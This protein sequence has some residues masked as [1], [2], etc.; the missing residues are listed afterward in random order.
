[1]FRRASATEDSAELVVVLGAKAD[2]LQAEATRPT[3]FV[4]TAPATRADAKSPAPT[5]GG[6]RAKT[7]V[8]LETAASIVRA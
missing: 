1:M 4:R 8:R 5:D 3:R 2:P 6:M 7:V